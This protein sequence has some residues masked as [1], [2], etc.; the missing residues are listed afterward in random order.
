MPHRAPGYFDPGVSVPPLWTLFSM[1]IFPPRR[2]LGRP[3]HRLKVTERAISSFDIED[4]DFNHPKVGLCRWCWQT[5]GDRP[6]FDSHTSRPCQKVSKGKREKW[7]ALF[8]CFTPIVYST[9]AARPSIDSTEHAEEERCGDL[10][11]NLNEPT[12][13]N[14][15]G[16]DR[17]ET[18]T[19]P[20]SFPS[21]TL[22]DAATSVPPT[23]E[24][25]RFISTDEYRKLEKEHQALRE[26]HQQLERVTQVLLARQ[27]LQETM[28]QTPPT[29]SAIKPPPAIDTSKNSSP[30]RS[31]AESSPLD[32]LVQHMDSQSTD[33]DV[34]GLMEEM[35]S[36]HR[37]LSRMNSGL[38]TASRSTIHH[39]PP[40]PP[41]RAAAL[42]VHRNLGPA[43]Q[44]AKQSLTH[45]PPPPSIPDSGYGTE[46]RRGSLGDVLMG[47]NLIT[48]PSSLD[49]P[50]EAKTPTQQ[51]SFPWGDSPSA[52]TPRATAPTPSS[53]PNSQPHHGFFADQEMPDYGDDSLSLFFPDTQH[54]NS[55][56]LEFPTFDFPL[57]ID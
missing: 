15:E 16:H 4:S 6:T 32:D 9:N 22:S 43:H 36:T 18:G 23:P 56:P 37:S 13:F 47:N 30:R 34:Q 21:P 55:P 7:R 31:T 46:Q 54:D 38:S 2:H 39:V 8:D 24:D 57:Q 40:S 52:H 14:D 10:F 51:E 45:R 41:P 33:V 20:T 17:D 3:A 1:L 29:N 48:P 35:E 12:I 5:F 28:R 26:K 27:I 25:G 49:K 11:G 19:P 44:Q 50:E 53:Q 42:P